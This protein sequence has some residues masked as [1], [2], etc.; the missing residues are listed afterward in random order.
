MSDT[1][2]ATVEAGNRIRLPAEWA[3][4][5]GLENIAELERTPEGIVVRRCRT[6]SWD[7]VY[8]DKLSIGQQASTSGS[9]EV[10][11]DDLFL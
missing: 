3:A 2:I 10:N 9:S 4:D 5:L 11:A 7:D 6:V 1:K 8:A